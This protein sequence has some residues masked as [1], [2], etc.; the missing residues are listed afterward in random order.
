MTA[1]RFWRSRNGA[2]AFG[3]ATVLAAIAVIEAGVWR[4]PV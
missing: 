2:R 1:A 4:R 3:A